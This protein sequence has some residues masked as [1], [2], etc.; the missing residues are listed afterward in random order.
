MCM[1]IISGNCIIIIHIDLPFI[2]LALF[3]IFI[4]LKYT[5]NILKGKKNSIY[6]KKKNMS[7]KVISVRNLFL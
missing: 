6:K 3:Y 5:G 7:I 4:L 1:Y 2:V